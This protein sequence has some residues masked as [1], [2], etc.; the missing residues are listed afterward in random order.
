MAVLCVKPGEWKLGVVEPKED[1]L[2]SKSLIPWAIT[3]LGRREERKG[4]GGGGGVEGCFLPARTSTGV[5]ENEDMERGR[6]GC[7]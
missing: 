4:K 7:G 2:L 1:G 5:V 6:R 3:E